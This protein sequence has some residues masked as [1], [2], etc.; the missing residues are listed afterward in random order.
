MSGSSN[1]KKEKIATL[2]ISSLLLVAMVVAVTVGVITTSHDAHESHESHEIATSKKAIEAFCAPTHYKDVCMNRLTAAVSNITDP[3]E[4]VKDAFLV[5]KQEIASALNKSATIKAGANDT[6]ALQALEICREVGAYSLNDLERSIESLTN[7]GAEKL[8]Q[9]I[10]DVKVWIG[11][12]ITYQEACFDAFENT[13]SDAGQKMRQLL[14][15]SRE[16]T[17]NALTIINEAASIQGKLHISGSKPNINASRRLLNVPRAG[18]LPAWLSDE[19]RHIFQLPTADIKPDVVVAHDGSGQ[20]RTI[21]EALHLVPKNNAGAFVIYIKAGVYHEHVEVNKKMTNVVFIG[22]GPNKTKITGNK[23]FADGIQTFKTATVDVVGDG[24]MAKD[25]GFENSAG[26]AKHQAVAIRVVSDYSVFFN[27][28]FDG[29]QDTLYAV[30]S[31]QFYRDCTV[32]GT[33]DFIFGDALA[34][35]QNCKMVIRKP[36]D[37]Q[38]CMVTAQGRT[39]P[40]GPGAIILQNC[41]ITSD[42]EY[43]P[44]RTKNKAFLGRPWKEYSRTIIMQS[45]IDDAIAPEGWTPWAGNFGLDTLYYAEYQNRGP[46]AAQTNR[47][48]WAGLKKLTPDQAQDFT[49]GKIFANADAWI[50]S[51]GCPYYHDMASV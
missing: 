31:R 23:N 35:F 47:V 26:A 36:L 14:N 1:D 19:K 13:T 3:K 39:V 27:C 37:N 7:F 42:P 29:Y 6:R 20:V 8:G 51:S 38:Q 28:Q 15:T 46:G 48:K 18:E 12:A 40:D 17:E 50:K 41:T 21:R 30:R 44:V 32:S 5:A 45:F 9:F 4:L 33:I 22:D 10:E 2:G 11:G 25:I 43:Y 24:F 49:P 16:L 34:V